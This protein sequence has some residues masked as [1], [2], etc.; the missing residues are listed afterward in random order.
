LQW[1]LAEDCTHLRV[2]YGGPIVYRQTTY[3]FLPSP[4]VGSRWLPLKS[5]RLLQV[6]FMS[7]NI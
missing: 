1:K 2:G 5:S 7:L 3:E 6:Y 4:V